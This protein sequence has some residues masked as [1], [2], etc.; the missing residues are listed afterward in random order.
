MKNIYPVILFV[1]E[2]RSKEG[3]LLCRVCCTLLLLMTFSSSGFYLQLGKQLY[4]LL[5][6]EF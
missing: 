5:S 6:W 2:E 3:W 4:L 1:L